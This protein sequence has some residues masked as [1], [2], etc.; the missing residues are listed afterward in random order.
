MRCQLVAVAS[1]FGPPKKL[2]TQGRSSS[3]QVQ[4]LRGWPQTCQ[5]G[6]GDRI[7]IERAIGLVRRLGPRRTADPAVDDEMRHVDALRRQ[8]ARQALRQAAQRELAHREG[9]RV[10]IALHAGGRAGQQDRARPCGSI[11]R[12]ACCATRKPPKPDTAMARATSAGSSS[13]TGPRAS[14]SAL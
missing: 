2:S 8:F 5:I 1:I 13:I 7:G 11:R 9:R 4:A 3:S 6:R 14:G 10:R 12:A